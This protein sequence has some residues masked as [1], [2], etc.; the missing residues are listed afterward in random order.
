MA[1]KTSK[2]LISAGLLI[3]LIINTVKSFYPIE[4]FYKGVILGIGITV[5][6]FGLFWKKLKD[7]SGT[8]PI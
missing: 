5:F 6:F 3:V 7:S 4:D 1:N 8:K 2:I